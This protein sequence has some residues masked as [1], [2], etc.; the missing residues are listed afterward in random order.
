M[1]PLS[2]NGTIDLKELHTVIDKLT[3]ALESIDQDKLLAIAYGKG[4]VTGVATKIL[5]EEATGKLRVKLG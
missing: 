5:V 4:D 1:I 2:K 3:K